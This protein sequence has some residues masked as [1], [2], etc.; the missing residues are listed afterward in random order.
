MLA[1]GRKRLLLAEVAEKYPSGTF[2][3]KAKSVRA[4]RRR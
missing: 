2:A 4:G 3:H 1:A